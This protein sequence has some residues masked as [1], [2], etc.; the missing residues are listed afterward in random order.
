MWF[1]ADCTLGR[2]R[3]RDASVRSRLCCGAPLM[4]HPDPA[5][6]VIHP[7]RPRPDAEAF[8]KRLQAGNRAFAALAEALEE[9]GPPTEKELPTPAAAESCP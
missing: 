1:I 6:T 4:A 8:L 2:R 3:L 5:E 9:I 7:D